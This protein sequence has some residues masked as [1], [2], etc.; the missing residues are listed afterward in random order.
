MTDIDITGADGTTLSVTLSAWQDLV[1]L[2][3]EAGVDIVRLGVDGEITANDATMLARWLSDAELEVVEGGDRDRLRVRGGCDTTPAV[4]RAA[5]VGEHLGM[6]AA[7]DQ[8]R[9]Y[10]LREASGAVVTRPLDHVDLDRVSSWV[11]FFSTCGGATWSW[12]H[13]E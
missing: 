3:G 12:S 4:A 11:V 13:T 9:S 7:R 5:R 2:A 1:E 6:T 10:L 8:A